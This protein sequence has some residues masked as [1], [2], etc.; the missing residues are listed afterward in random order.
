[1]ILVTGGAGYIGS[2]TLHMLVAEGKKCVTIDDLSAGH[3]WAVPAGV[4]LIV[5]NIADENLVAGVIKKYSVKTVIHFAAF[6]RV[7]ESVTEPLKY[8]D[9]NFINGRRF[10][11]TCAINGVENFVF[12]STSAVYGT[13]ASVPVRES[14][15]VSPLSPYG[16]S[17][18]MIEWLLRDLEASGKSR[19]KSVALRYFNVAGAKVAGGL[20]Q[21]TLGATQLIKVAAEVACGKK[22]QLQIFGTDYPTP[23]GTCIR[24]YIHVEDLADAHLR[25]IEYL[26]S[27]GISVTLNCGY[28]HGYSV[29]EVI[30]AM[31]RVSG[32]DFRVVESDRRAGDP[33]SAYAD[34]NAIRSTLGWRPKYADLDLICRTSYEWERV[35]LPERRS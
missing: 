26:E 27:G 12:S 17:K 29:R 19:M 24:D 2:H 22:P 35:G 28:G 8:Y 5:G 25:A 6:L 23:D 18:L 33:V 34:T 32:V 31:K 16:K 1:M 14:D 15:P 4:E 21:A 7:E 3:S 10:I 20:G 30:A 13:P 9:N 11:E